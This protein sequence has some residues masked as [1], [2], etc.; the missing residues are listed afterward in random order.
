MLCPDRFEDQYLAGQAGS[1]VLCPVL[2]RVFYCLNWKSLLAL[3]GNRDQLA[4]Q[5]S[6]DPNRLDQ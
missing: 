4:I 3:L 6:L 5:I 1:N 2:S